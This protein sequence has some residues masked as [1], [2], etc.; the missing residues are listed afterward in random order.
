M[1][2][3]ETQMESNTPKPCLGWIGHTQEQRTAGQQEEQ[4]Q[5]WDPEGSSVIYVLK[6]THGSREPSYPLSACVLIT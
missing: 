2:I 5:Q 1:V 3:T 6:C 4:G